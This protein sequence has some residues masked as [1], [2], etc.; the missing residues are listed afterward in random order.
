[1]AKV[2]ITIEDTNKKENQINIRIESDPAFPGPAA[3]DQ[4]LTHA[5]ECGLIA[6]QA[7]VDPKSVEIADNDEEEETRGELQDG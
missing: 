2:I 3:K 7:I 4:T 6:M 5:Q 1:M